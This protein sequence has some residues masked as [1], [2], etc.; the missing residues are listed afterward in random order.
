MRKHIL[1]LSLIISAIICFASCQNN[2][3]LTS[4]DY[5]QLA[6]DN[7]L[8]SPQLALTY[9]DTVH[10]L[11]P[12]DVPARRQADT[13]KWNIEYRL[14]KQTVA[15]TD[16]IL[17]ILQDSLPKLTGQFKFIKDE[18][19]QD[20]GAFEHKLLTTERNT[21]RTYLKPVVDEHGKATITSHHVATT[22]EHN[23]L[24]ATADSLSISTQPQAAENIHTFTDLDLSHQTILFDSPDIINIYQFIENNQDKRIK[25]TL[26][27]NGEKNLY[28]FY[29]NNNEKQIFTDCH[30]L[31]TL[32]SDHY[33]LFTQQQQ[34]TR[35]MEL[36][37]KRLSITE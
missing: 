32:L 27:Y 17:K 2:K 22:T 24:T 1:S 9:T 4:A 34:L 21:E 28:H 6:R 33:T 12:K 20:L 26:S 3:E 13:I 15:Y 11:F 25:I 36:L 23:T 30:Q 10:L 35:K 19:Y 31:A 8:S 37:E 5:L 7:S 18:N 14:A 16:S 29:L